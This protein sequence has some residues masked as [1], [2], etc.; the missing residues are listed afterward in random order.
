[1]TIS[2]HDIAVCSWSLRPNGMQDLATKVRQLGLE[3]VQLML[4]DLLQ[5]DDKRKYEQL[6]HLRTS[7]IRFTGGMMSFP[8]EDYTTIDAIHRTGGFLPD[9]SWPLRKRL[10]IEGAK[11]AR[12]LGMR[13]IG[14]HVGFVPP[15][16]DPKYGVMLGRV[17]ELAAAFGEQGIDLLMETGQER[18]DELF[19]FLH[20]LAAANVFINF[21]PANMILYGAG[22]PI[23]AIR[24]L[25]RFIHHVHVKDATASGKPGVEWGEEAPFG[26]GQVNPRLF[27]G[28]L[29]DAGYTGP[30]AIEREAGNDRMGDVRIA[31]ESLRKATSEC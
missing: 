8:E 17:R 4:L 22:N 7:G 19:K 20:D 9:E 23:D 26:T 24:T 10:S 14:T 6:G 3:H 30:L 25:G 27:L 2:V 31:I 28:A 12:E 18:A 5:L 16:A 1:M 15:K 13:L 29:R 21:D 11:L